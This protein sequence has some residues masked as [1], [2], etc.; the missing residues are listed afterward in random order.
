MNKYKSIICKGQK[1]CYYRDNT[2]FDL[3]LQIEKDVKNT[4]LNRESIKRTKSVHSLKKYTDELERIKIN[5]KYLPLNN[6][7]CFI[8]YDSLHIALAL[9]FHFLANPIFSAII[10]QVLPGT[11]KLFHTL[12][13]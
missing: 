7:M 1:L 4:W 6:E 5:V 2:W 11:Y 12:I 13:A 10:Q 9:L 8:N 3:Q